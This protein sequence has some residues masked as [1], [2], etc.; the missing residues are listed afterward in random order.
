[1]FPFDPWMVGESIGFLFEAEV[2]MICMLTEECPNTEF[3][4]FHLTIGQLPL[5]EATKYHN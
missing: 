2:G 3:P 1:M 4:E 5:E